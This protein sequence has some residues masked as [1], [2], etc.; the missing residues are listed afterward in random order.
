MDGIWGPTRIPE[1]AS[2]GKS[3]RPCAYPSHCATVALECSSFHQLHDVAEA[4]NYIHSRNLVHGS[5][6]GVCALRPANNLADVP[7]A[8]ILVDRFGCARVTDFSLTTVHP[9]RVSSCNVSELCDHN[10]RWTA[11]EVSEETGPLTKKADVFS[12]AML[13]V[14]VGFARFLRTRPAKHIV[15]SMKIFTGEFP[16]HTFQDVTAIL[17]IRKGE[18]PPR[19]IDPALSDDMWAWMRRC[20]DQNPQLRP[21]MSGVVQN[22]TL[23][24]L[25][26][27]LP[28]TEASPEFQVALNQFYNSTEYKVYVGHLCGAEL[29]EFVNFLDA[30]RSPFEPFIS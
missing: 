5:I 9:N 21:E 4:L 29:E 16:F 10:T 22:L 18:R 2:K 30:V 13:M 19:P 12:F 27:L 23:S 14:E 1:E 26:S 25:R 8:N 28:F 15:V 17:K 3:T 24:L 20:W 6:M 11:P 7:Q